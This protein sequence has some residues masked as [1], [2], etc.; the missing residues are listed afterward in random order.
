MNTPERYHPFLVTLHW[1]TVLLL[2]G[3]GM[4]SESGRR[5][6]INIHMII[7]A[8]L[9]LVMIIRVIVRFTTKSPAWAKT[10]SP[11]LDKLGELVHLGLYLAVFF[12]LGMG[13]LIAYNRNLFAYLLD[14]TATVG[15]RA[16]F[17]GR[18]HQLGWILAVGLV[19]LHIGAAFYHQFII[20][21]NLMARSWYGKRVI[22]EPV[23]PLINVSP[24]EDNL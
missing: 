16:G 18:I 14:T 6:P 21:D 22:S 15:R 7:G 20:N 9:L 12:I 1:L 24:T 10:G 4:L 5:S 17:I 23:H 11:L 13:G 3:A 8:L 19:L 2:F